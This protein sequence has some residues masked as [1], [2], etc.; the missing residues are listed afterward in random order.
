MTLFLSCGVKPRGREA[1]G[2][3]IG[4]GAFGIGAALKFKGSACEP[5]RVTAAE[6][7]VLGQF[8]ATQIDDVALPP[9]DRQADKIAVE[10]KRSIDVCDV[11]HHIGQ[12]PVSERRSEEHTSE[13]QSLMRISYAVF[14]L[15]K[16]KKRKTHD[17]KRRQQK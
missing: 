7:Q 11:E 1:F 15:K 17:K 16:K 8:A 9:V 10:G 4:K 13:L 12:A 2:L 3:E 6:D 14:C 5:R